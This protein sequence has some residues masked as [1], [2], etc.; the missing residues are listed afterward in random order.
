L[1]SIKQIHGGVKMANTL[2]FLKNSGYIDFKE[3]LVFGTNSI[4]LIPNVSTISTLR[5]STTTI[6][7]YTKNGAIVWATNAS[8]VTGMTKFHGTIAKIDNTYG[9][10]VLTSAD[11]ALLKLGKLNFPSGAITNIATLT[12]APTPASALGTD[13]ALTNSRFYNSSEAIVLD[14]TT[15]GNLVLRNGAGFSRY[16][17]TTAGASVL[18]TTTAKII[19]SVSFDDSYGEYGANKIEGFENGS[20][21]INCIDTNSESK[22]FIARLGVYDTIYTVE[23]SL[24]IFGD[25]ICFPSTQSNYR[26]AFYKDEFKK[27]LRNGIISSGGLIE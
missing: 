9:W 8:T 25:F 19:G 3:V 1:F 2:S 26:K 27:F 13:L 18:Q 20:I 4:P 5:I 14:L 22:F 12:G 17:F 16:E 23:A 15:G 11:G 6:T 10:V 7:G 21:K 24:F